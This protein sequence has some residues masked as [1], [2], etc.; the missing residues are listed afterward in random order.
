MA[1]VVHEKAAVSFGSDVS[2]TVPSGTRKSEDSPE[3]TRP[4]AM[5]PRGRGCSVIFDPAPKYG[6][7]DH[8][9]EASSK[10][11]TPRAV[12]WTSGSASESSHSMG[13]SN[14]GSGVVNA[15]TT[16]GGAEA[17]A[18]Q[19]KLAV[20]TTVYSAPGVTEKMARGD[21]VPTT[22]LNVRGAAHAPHALRCGCAYVPVGVTVMVKE[23]AACVPACPAPS[24]HVTTTEPSAPVTFT[25]VGAT[26]VHGDTHGDGVTEAVPETDCVPEGVVE[27]V[28]DTDCVPDGESDKVRVVDTDEVCVGVGV[29][30]GDVVG[31]GVTV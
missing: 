15:A 10:G 14:V 30:V 3:K 6:F 18:A 17:S 7:S 11:A 2:P 31:E 12:V 29:R 21:R 16:T 25:S 20:T 1:S 9:P 27:A 13:A 4:R 23:L 24:A 5:R 22:R 28:P 8:L 26:P 19:K